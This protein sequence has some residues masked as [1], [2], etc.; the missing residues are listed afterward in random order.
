MVRAALE[1]REGAPLTALAQSAF[2]VDNV[3]GGANYQLARRLYQRRGDL[4]KTARRDGYVWVQPTPTLCR[5]ALL[6]PTSKHTVERQDGGG[7]AM[8]NA[9]SM[10]KSRRSFD[11]PGERGDLMGAFGAKREATGDRYH[12]YQDTFSPEDH[13]LVP[14]STRFNSERRVGET[15]DRYRGAWS[16]AAEEHRDGV[17][18]TLTTDPSR[19]D[20]LLD[21]ARGLLDDVNRLKDWVSRSPE[22]GPARAG[23]RPP[24]VVSVEFTERGLPHVHVAFFGVRWLAKHSALSRYWS[25]SRDRGEVVWIDRIRTQGGRWTWVRDSEDRQHGDAAG[26]SPRAYLS[27][28]V[29]LLAASADATAGEVQESADALRAAGGGDDNPDADALSR[30]KEVWRAALYWA[31][32]LPV[33]TISP[34]LKPDDDGGDGP[35]SVAPDGT[36]LPADA[37]SR[38][39]YVGTAQYHEFPG[40]VRDGATVLV[41]RGQPPP[42]TA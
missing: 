40:Y 13:L 1:H 26:T 15:R 31:T 17:V 5:R 30:G 8:S 39:R 28:G 18:V 4:F 19:Y 34:S 35:V 12:A 7:V 37:P 10:L 24:S 14:Y 20:S 16:R 32:E 41:R 29:D 6:D 33:C 21:A 23:H 42:D 36:P 11:A 38:W 27:E 9:Q 2:G 22:S 25:E 3:T